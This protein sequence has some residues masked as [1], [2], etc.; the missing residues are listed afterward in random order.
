MNQ[1]L[2]MEKDPL[3]KLTWRGHE[4]IES[5]PA[6][7]DHARKLE[8]TLPSNYN[9]SLFSALHRDEPAAQLEE[10]DV[11]GGPELL[12]RVATVSGLEEFA[13][14]TRPLTAARATI[15]V[16]SPPKVIITLPAGNTEGK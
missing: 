5:I 1:E 12:A 7:L 11:S 3:I 8:I 15:Q 10:I 2:I 14:L 9:H 16:E 4:T 13:T 6:L